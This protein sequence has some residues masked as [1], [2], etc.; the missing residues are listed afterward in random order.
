MLWQC[1][2]Q[3]KQVL[4]LSHDPVNEL[5]AA[6]AGHHQNHHKALA[7]KSR[8]KLS[9]AIQY[10]A[11]HVWNWGGVTRPPTNSILQPISVCS[12][13]MRRLRSDWSTGDDKLGMCGKSRATKVWPSQFQSCSRKLLSQVKKVENRKASQLFWTK[14]TVV[15]QATLQ[16]FWPLRRSCL[17]GRLQVFHQR[18]THSLQ[19]QAT[20]ANRT[21]WQ[22]P[23]D[24]CSQ[25]PNQHVPTAFGGSEVST[26]ST[27]RIIRSHDKGNVLLGSAVLF[28]SLETSLKTKRRKKKQRWW[29][30]EVNVTNLLL[31]ILTNVVSDIQVQDLPILQADH[32]VSILLR[33]RRSNMTEVY[34]MPFISIHDLPVETGNLMT[35]KCWKTLL[36]NEIL[37]MTMSIMSFV[38][39]VR[40][41][42]N[43]FR[44]ALANCNNIPA[45]FVDALISKDCA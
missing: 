45:S 21:R 35:L 23:M 1:K 44:K 7:S 34:N 42:I 38:R 24:V 33:P 5:A 36:D 6:G 39:I 17:N 20:T 40:R 4:L 19:S 43:I 37:P 29:S 2:F 12:F 31:V 11:K 14:A 8:S 27:T 16:T 15:R 9:I 25:L 3:S 26:N 30:H 10:F 22:S 41:L 13:W 32:F 18:G 28:S